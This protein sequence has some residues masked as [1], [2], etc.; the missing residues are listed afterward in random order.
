MTNLDSIL[1]SRDITLS[2][3]VHLGKVRTSLVAQMVNCLP[4]IWETRV[5]SLGWEDPLEKEMAT[6]SSTL[7]WKGYGFSCGHVW[8]WEFDC[9]EGWATKNWC[10][11]TTVLEKT[12]ESSL[13]SKEVNPK[14]NQ[15]WIFIGNTDAEAKAPILWPPD[16]KSIEKDPDAGRDWEQEK[17][18]T[19][20]E[21]AGWHHWLDGHEFEWTPGVGGGQGGL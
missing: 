12:L 9:K 15:S 17:G 7:A 4:T 5:R 6:H 21:M 20:D 8:M 3:K 16:V 2:T 13:D 1:K 19:E 11:W 14:G 10:F 18:M